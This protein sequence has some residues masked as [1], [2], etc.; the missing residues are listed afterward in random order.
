MKR[1]KRDFSDLR[2]DIGDLGHALS[3][4]G[5]ERGR[6][7]YQQTAHQ[8]L[9][10]RDTGEAALDSAQHMLRSRPV[11][12]TLMVVAVGCIVAAAVSAYRK[13]HYRDG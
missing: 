6:T 9:R 12:S 1:L 2:S 3:N 4:I 11:S 13:T 7:L 8:G 5:A 10:L